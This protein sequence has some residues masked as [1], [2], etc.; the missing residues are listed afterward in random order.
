M[1]RREFIAGLGATVALPLAAHAQQPMP[2]VGYLSSRSPGESE[3][4]VAAF[5]QG[6]GEAGYVVGQT[7]RSM[8]PGSEPGRQ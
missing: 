1:R 5:R 4:V 8:G 3:T 7:A 6:L 2:V